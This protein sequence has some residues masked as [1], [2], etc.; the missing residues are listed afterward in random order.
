VV[1]LEKESNAMVKKRRSRA[2]PRLLTDVELELMTIVWERG[3][4]TV[5]DVAAALPKGRRLAYTSVATMLKILEQKRFLTARK[6][7]LAFVYHP[8]VAKAAYEAAC[9]SDMV[10][11]VFAGEP[12]ALVARL[13]NDRELTPEALREIEQLVGALAGK[14]EEET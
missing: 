1:A 6:D 12:A 4:A 11:R 3:E 14:A 5:K 10:T 13:L 7:G 9:V 8:L 2:A